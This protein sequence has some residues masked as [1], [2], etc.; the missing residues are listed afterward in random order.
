MVLELTVAFSMLGIELTKPLPKLRTDTSDESRYQIHEKASEATPRKSDVVPIGKGRPNGDV[1]KFIVAC[2]RP[3][4]GASVVISELFDLYREWSIGQG[5][6]ALSRIKFEEA[7]VA[8]ADEAELK[9]VGK[10]TY[11]LQLADSAATV[12]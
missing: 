11:G 8:L 3:V 5:L 9:R 4:V 1:A 12:M 2:F 7:F 10:V 6:R